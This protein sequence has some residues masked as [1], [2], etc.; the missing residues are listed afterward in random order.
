MGGA[1]SGRKPDPVKRLVGFNQPSKTGPSDLVYMPNYSGLKHGLQKTKPDDPWITDHAALTSL[2]W[3]AAGHTIDTD[4]DMGGND[5]VKTWKIKTDNT[6]LRLFVNADEADQYL[7]INRSNATTVA[8]QMV[9]STYLNIQNNMTPLSDGGFDLGASSK[10]WKDLYLSGDANIGT[11]A[12]ITGDC[13][14][15]DVKLEDA[16]DI[17][18]ITPDPAK[19]T[20]Y[21]NIEADEFIGGLWWVPTMSGSDNLFSNILAIK[22]R[23]YIVNNTIPQIYFSNR[24]LSATCYIEYN[25]AADRLDFKFASG[26]YT[27]DDDITAT[28]TIKGANYQSGDGSAGIT[29]TETG[30]TDFDIVIKDGLI[31]SFTKNN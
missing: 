29:Q 2:N 18:K 23:L 5:I 15:G 31:T 27:F 22:D 26:G 9:G 6:S 10:K 13:F 1:G 3:A 25:V 20:V 24:A 12:N 21:W 17:L 11:D 14:I 30:V 4:I 8:L 7:S 28:G 16:G 19:T